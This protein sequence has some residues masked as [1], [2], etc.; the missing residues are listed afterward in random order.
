MAFKRERLCLKQIVF[1]EKDL[2]LLSLHMSK[3]LEFWSSPGRIS[4]LAGEMLQVI[5]TV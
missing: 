4:K 5:N 1:K 2:L 3:A